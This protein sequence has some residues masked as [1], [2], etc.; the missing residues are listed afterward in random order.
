MDT[1]ELWLTLAILVT[2]YAVW[3]SLR[4]QRAIKED[5]DEP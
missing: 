4:V 1:G 5:G 3:L 2:V